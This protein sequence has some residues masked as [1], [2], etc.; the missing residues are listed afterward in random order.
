MS[1]AVGGAER[2]R[3]IAFQAAF[4]AWTLLLLPVGVVAAVYSRTAVAALAPFWARGALWLLE[5]IVGLRHHVRGADRVPE[6]PVM[7]A[8]KHQ[9]AWE[10]IALNLIVRDPV[11]VLKRELVAIPVFGW[12][13]RRIGMIAV[14]RTGGGSALRS[15]IMAARARVAEGRSVVIF[16]EGTRTAPGRRQPYHPG[17]AALYT[18]LDIPVVPVALNSG[19]FWPRRS[20]GIRPGR[21]TI[22]FLPAI[23]PGLPRREFTQRLE[24]TIEDATSKLVEEAIGIHPYLEISVARDTGNAVCG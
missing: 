9:S 11:F 22:E 17:V 5:R 15:M 4:Y 2:W 6:G 20:A 13:L 8:V 7:L 21:V 24:S 19:L 3:G 10:T 18:A 23:T 1:A 12:L 16:P 14:D